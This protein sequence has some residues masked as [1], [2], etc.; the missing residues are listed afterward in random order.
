MKPQGVGIEAIKL[1]ELIDLGLERGHIDPNDL[2]ASGAQGSILV[3]GML[4][5]WAIRAFCT[6]EDFVDYDECPKDVVSYGL[7]S[8]GYDIRVAGRYKI[9]TDALCA[10]VSPRALPL[11]SYLN[12]DITGHR[13][14]T[15]PNVKKPI[16]SA[17][18]LGYDDPGAR[19]VCPHADPNT[20]NSIKI[21][22]NSFALAETVER[23][24]IPRNV[25][26]LCL[27]KSTYARCGII[28][29]FTPFEPGWRGV[30]TVEISNSTP[31]PVE[32]LAWQGIG[33]AQYQLLLGLPE[34]SYAEKK[35][36]KYQDQTGLTMP[37]VK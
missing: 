14:A 15:V 27:G 16:C 21:P 17:C 30:V 10:T 31:V 2:V 11:D 12:V 29:N 28:V 36:A 8:S 4:P 26:V 19:F 37:S 18:S 13:W 32:V 22:P 6:I 25:S 9:F 24:H 33:Q 23:L 7:S 34:R 5:D 1:R 3:G 35:N 20:P